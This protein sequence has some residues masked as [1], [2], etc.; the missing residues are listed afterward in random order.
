MYFSI[1]I[2]VFFHILKTVL[3]NYFIRYD[4]Y[5][6]AN[7]LIPLH[8]CAKVKVLIFQHMNCAP[9]FNIVMLT[10]NFSVVKF[11]VHTLTSPVYLM[12]LPLMMRR[13]QY[14]A[15]FGGE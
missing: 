11:A 2:S 10:S 5:W 1:N 4:V 15:S 9:G 14:G 12:N 6:Q 7:V 3:I 8:W 13:V